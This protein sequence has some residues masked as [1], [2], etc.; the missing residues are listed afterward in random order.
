MDFFDCVPVTE[1]QSPLDS[2]LTASETVL[3][4]CV[5]DVQLTVVWP[6]VGFCTSMLD[7]LSAATLPVAPAG[8]FDVVAASA[9]EA[10]AVAATSA[11]APA[12]KNRVQRRRVVLR[13]V[14]VCMSVCPSFG[15]VLWYVI[16]SAGLRYS[17][18]RA[19]MGARVAARLA[20]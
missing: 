7:A 8:A 14:G 2:E 1:T 9:V 20:G 17:F 18:R 4:N 13:L 15:C 12:P 19:S 11:V 6:L 16:S 10:R 5:V 3:E